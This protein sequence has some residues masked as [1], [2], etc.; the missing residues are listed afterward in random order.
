[1]LCALLTMSTDTQA[2]DT[3]L[4][5]SWTSITLSV[6]DL[7]QAMALWSGIF[8]FEIRAQ[9]EGPDEGLAS[10]WSISAGEIHRQAL[11]ATPGADSG[12]VHFVEFDQPG[13]AV[14]DGAQVFDLVPK[15]L[16]IYVRDIAARIKELKAAGWVFNTQSFSDVTAPDGT[17]FHE[18]HMRGHDGINIV[19]LELLDTEMNFTEQGYAGVG[20]LITIVDDAGKER[21]FVSG[22]LGLSML[23][24][25]ILSG[26]EIEK[27]IGLPQGS[28][29][30]V[31]I[32]GSADNPLGE[33]E[34]IDYRGVEGNDLYARTVPKFTGALH[35]TYEVARL[36]E[37]TSRLDRAGISWTDLGQRST[38]SAS[39]SFIRVLSPGGLRIE[40]VQKR[41]PGQDT[42]V[43][44]N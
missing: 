23:H 30:D 25:N 44:G 14:R 16:D 21:D 37:F 28:A 33:M 29:L 19:L 26:P 41:L 43:P 18:I 11:L 10:G 9:K 31:S 22:V 32:W 13:P 36:E 12:M 35:L 38:L 24:D 4:N 15:N 6:S 1:M 3:N 7:D 20:P 27:M 40:V 17:R 5:P 2:A 39:G 42:S 8:G 34:V